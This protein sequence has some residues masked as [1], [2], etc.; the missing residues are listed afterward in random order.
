MVKIF[1][2]WVASMASYADTAAMPT[3]DSFEP[4][5]ATKIKFDVQLADGV[6]VHNVIYDKTSRT[7]K[8]TLKFRTAHGFKVTN[9]TVNCEC[10]CQLTYKQFI[11]L[12]KKSISIVKDRIAGTDISGIH[13]DMLLVQEMMDAAVSEVKLQS[14]VLVSTIGEKA[15]AMD[16]VVRNR[17]NDL[18]ATRY[19]CA[20]LAADKI[21]CRFHPIDFNPIAF[22]E[23]LVGKSWEHVI[24]A[25]NAGLHPDNWISLMIEV[26]GK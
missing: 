6:L 16:A 8:G 1:I 26:N 24:Y 20:A 15:A 19:I 12:L 2:F 22:N 14:S 21:Q 18:E 7:K 9:G 13:F 4:T 11:E 3:S 10:S 17:L 5:V 25:R 23:G